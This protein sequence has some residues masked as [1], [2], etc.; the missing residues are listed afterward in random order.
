MGT[1]SWERGRPARKWD[2]EVA[3]DQCGRDARVPRTPCPR[4]RLRGVK[5]ASNPP[6]PTST[7]EKHRLRGGKKYLDPLSTPYISIAYEQ[8]PGRR[9]DEMEHGGHDLLGL[10]AA[11]GSDLG[12]SPFLLAPR[13]R[14][15]GD[16]PAGGDLASTRTFGACSRANASVTASRAR[17][18]P[19]L[20]RRERTPVAAGWRRGSIRRQWPHSRPRPRAPPSASR[21]AA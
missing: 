2:G 11:P 10:A 17:A 21:R 16:E 13:P 15:V 7:T 12:I 9:R 3:V 8:R 1:A 19:S 4:K 20:P 14:D 6:E 5:S 18:P